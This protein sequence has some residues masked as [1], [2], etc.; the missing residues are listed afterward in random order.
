M[1]IFFRYY[2]SRFDNPENIN[3]A[4]EREANKT[5]YRLSGNIMQQLANTSIMVANALYLLASNGTKP[6]EE[7]TMETNLVPSI[8]ISPFFFFFSTL[9]FYFTFFISFDFYGFEFEKK[10]A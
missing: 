6:E 9:S 8:L 3:L 7:L 10:R 5:Y 4:Y 2:N 1:V